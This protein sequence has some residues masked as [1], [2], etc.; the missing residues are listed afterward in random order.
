HVEEGSMFRALTAACALAVA[1]VT[2]VSAA[3]APGVTATEIKVGGIFPFSG[4][5]SSIGLVGRAV[6]AYVQSINDRGGI[7]GRK[8][9]Y[10]A[11][12]DA[13]TPPQGREHARQRVPGGEIA[14]L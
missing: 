5:A 10:H 1:L 6:L 11:Y 7:G 13:H 8:I 3:D 12:Q 14:V 4:P 9:H 2:S